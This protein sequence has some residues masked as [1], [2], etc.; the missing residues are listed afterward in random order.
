MLNANITNLDAVFITHTHADHINGID[1]FRFLN[2]LMKKHI[3]LY[4]SEKSIID[5]RKRFSY[6]FEELS[7]EANGFYYKPCLI[8]NIAKKEFLLN[9]L[10][11]LSFPQNHG[12]SES[13][14]FRIN[15]MA[16][17]TDVI[18]FCEESFKLLYG[19]DMLIIDCLRFKPHK[20]HAHLNKVLMWIDKLKP[21]KSILTHMNYD[22]DYDHINSL[23]PTNCEAAFDGLILEC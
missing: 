10:R 20:T 6:V 22:V 8:P 3:N 11:V 15:N 18:D 21:K 13:T 14:G 17:C 1:D 9:E 12:F 23:L 2:V 16:Y 7:P 19:L 4:A 5:I